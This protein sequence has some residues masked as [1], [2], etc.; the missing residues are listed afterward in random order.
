MKCM[1]LVGGDDVA[2]YL[3]DAGLNLFDRQRSFPHAFELRSQV[4][5]ASPE[6]ATDT[7]CP[8][9]WTVVPEMRSRD[10]PNVVFCAYSGRQTHS[11][12]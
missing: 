4:V 10:C 9:G 6:A 7:T 12:Q 8:V 11:I 1:L 5:A 3:Y 2:N